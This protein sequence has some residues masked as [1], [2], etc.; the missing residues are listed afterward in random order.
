[1]ASDL[2]E[3]ATKALAPV[4]S[5][6]NKKAKERIVESIKFTLD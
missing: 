4:R 5:A 3:G 2:G 1:M 6:T